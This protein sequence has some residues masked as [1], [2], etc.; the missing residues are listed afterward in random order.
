MTSD[1]A[2]DPRSQHFRQTETQLRERGNSNVFMVSTTT[3][4]SGTGTRGK[5]HKVMSSMTPREI[6]AVAS[7]DNG[8]LAERL[9]EMVNVSGGDL[10]RDG[11]CMPDSIITKEEI[12]TKRWGLGLET[13]KRTLEVTMQ[14]GVRKY[15]HPVARRFKTRQQA[16]RYPRLSGKFY[17]NTM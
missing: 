6:L 5:L 10:R 9:K 11:I 1:A 17:T 7:A 3:Q 14:V 8:L 2:W 12:L 16:I 4:L 13:A 15:V